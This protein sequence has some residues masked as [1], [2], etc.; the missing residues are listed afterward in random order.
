MMFELNQF[1]HIE[2]VRDNSVAQYVHEIHHSNK[3]HRIFY[4]LFFPACH[5]QYMAY[6]L[7]IFCYLIRDD[8]NLISDEVEKTKVK[9]PKFYTI[10][11]LLT[12]IIYTF[13]ISF[14]SVRDRTGNLNM[15]QSLLLLFYL[16]PTIFNS[17]RKISHF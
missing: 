16:P 17:E 8:R 3:I 13:L 7:L 14:E 11:F 5:I 4:L 2:S 9:L 10:F 1:N 6:V 12:F 15:P